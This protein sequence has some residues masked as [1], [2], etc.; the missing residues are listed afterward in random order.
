MKFE[1]VE[2]FQSDNGQLTNRYF[3][4]AL[5]NGQGVTIGNALRRVL[6]TELEGTAISEVR[7]FGTNHEYGPISGVRED[8]LEI[9]LNLKQVKIQGLLE[10]P[11]FAT[12][13]VNGP[14][15][16]TARSIRL[17]TGLRVINLNQ[18][19]AAVS[20]RSN[21][22][23][24]LRIESGKGYSL[25]SDDNHALSPG[26][27]KVDSIFTPV[28]N[29]SFTLRDFYRFDERSVED[30]DL[31]ISTDGSIT[32]DQALTNSAQKL[33]ALFSSLVVCEP[34]ISL[35]SEIET[36]RQTLIEELQLSVRAYNCLKRVNIRTINDLKKYSIKELKGIKNFG[37]KCANEVIGK[38]RDRFD[39]I[40]E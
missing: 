27:L 25:S 20:D 10:K 7:V 5:E 14:N 11:Y 3:L 38:L 32:P 2:S 31:L 34:K 33:S 23:L 24:E 6:L 26:F 39:I 19:I 16:A 36:S 4:K 22:K 12:I 28:V 9:L 1:K 13:E 37:E 21:L 18:Y 8:V 29:V 40:L 30:L 15:L 17:P 35:P